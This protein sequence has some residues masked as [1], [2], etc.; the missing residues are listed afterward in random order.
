M[1]E[2]EG[3]GRSG[4]AEV[5]VARKPDGEAPVGQDG[6]VGTLDPGIDE[7]RAPSDG[8]EGAGGRGGV[9]GIDGSRARG[10]EDLR[11]G[12]QRLALGLRVS[13]HFL[14]EREGRRHREGQDHGAE[15]R[16]G[17]PGGER[18]G[19]AHTGLPA[20]LHGMESDAWIAHR[21]AA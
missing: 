12:A 7:V 21:R 19:K 13:I 3:E 15:D 9:S 18:A 8:V 6:T 14:P 1:A 20:T 16:Q 10:R 17:E 11:H 4:L 2:Q 5:D